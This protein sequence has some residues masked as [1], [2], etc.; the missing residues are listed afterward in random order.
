[1]YEELLDRT[2]NVDLPALC[3]INEE[4]AIVTRGVDDC[5]KYFKVDTAQNNGWLRINHYY[6]DGTITE[7]FE[8]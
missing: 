1:M 6:E 4:T 2:K 3:T 5:G 8:R 7:T